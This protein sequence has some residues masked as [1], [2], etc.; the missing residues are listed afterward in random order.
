MKTK[1]I[2]LGTQIRHILCLLDG[3]VQKVYDSKVP[4]YRPR[5][6]PITRA[7]QHKSPA[8]I[9]DIVEFTGLT[10]SAASQ[11]VSLMLRH[12]W[13]DKHK[14]RDA[15]QTAVVFSD[16]AKEALPTL[17]VLWAATRS[18]ADKIDNELSYPFSHLLDELTDA[19]EKKPFIDRINNE[20]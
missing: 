9:Q 5:F 2:G 13:L 10:Q 16:K 18:A 15:R 11:T 20:K 7:L 14:T 8:T 6:T 19:L 3:D 17:Q 12:G 4:G 1:S